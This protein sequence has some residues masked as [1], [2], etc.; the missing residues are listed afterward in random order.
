MI[1]TVSYERDSAGIIT[2]Q[3][4]GTPAAAWGRYG[5]TAE[6]LAEH[7]HA[8]R[9]LGWPEGVVYWSAA[10]GPA[11]GVAIVATSEGN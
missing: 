5:N 11:H 1:Y 4:L 7:P 10:T 2:R 8:E 6:L 3:P 9:L